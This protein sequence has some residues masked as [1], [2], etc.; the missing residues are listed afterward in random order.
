ME[1]LYDETAPER[2]R[3][4]AGH[5]AGCTACG[6]Q[7]KGW[8]ASLTELDQWR[9]STPR[10]AVRQWNTG[11]R[12]AAAAAVVLA[13]GF[14]L[15]RRTAPGVTELAELKASV[16]RLADTV[17]QDRLANLTNATMAATATA[18]AETSRMF[19]QFSLIQ[20]EQRAADQQAF[21]LAFQ[22]LDA[23]VDKVQT[24]VET[25]ALNTQE[26]FQQTHQNMTRLAY[27]LPIQKPTD[28]LNR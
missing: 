5:L 8:R 19:E 20:E 14:G 24:A 15:G 27:S 21:R 13:L 28:P 17:R 25:V 6:E 7:V 16:T 12:W 11:L 23:K 18:T 2:R 1:F 4:M 9:I 26:S 22:A 3:E 10:Q